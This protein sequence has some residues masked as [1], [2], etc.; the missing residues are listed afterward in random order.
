[1]YWICPD[2]IISDFIFRFFL[3]AFIPIIHLISF[4]F[5]VLSRGLLYFGLSVNGTGLYTSSTPLTLKAAAR[6]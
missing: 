3:S 2:R 6:S 4:P 5:S 1:M